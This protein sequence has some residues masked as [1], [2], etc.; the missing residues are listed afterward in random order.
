MD[1]QA[2]TPR[3]DAPNANQLEAAAANLAHQVS[4]AQLVGLIEHELER[5][6][7]DGNASGL[8]GWI[9]PGRG[10][11]EVDEYAVQQRH[12]DTHSALD[13]IIARLYPPIAADALDHPRAQTSHDAV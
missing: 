9:G 12:R 13:R 2:V 8:D 11:G 5:V 7:D 6:W 10:A 1:Q 3:L 4:R